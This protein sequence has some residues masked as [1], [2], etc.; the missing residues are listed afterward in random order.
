MLYKIVIQNGKTKTVTV[1]KE[2]LKLLKHRIRIMYTVVPKLMGCKLP[3]L[4]STGPFRWWGGE[5]GSDVI[6][7]I[8]Q[9]PAPKGRGDTYL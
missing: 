6:L 1:L 7:K 8:M 9:L 2:S 5:E 4:W 3:A